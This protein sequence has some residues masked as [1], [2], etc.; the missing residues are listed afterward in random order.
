MVLQS[1]CLGG[2]GLYSLDHVI[3][4][5]LEESLVQSISFCVIAFIGISTKK[6]NVRIS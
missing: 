3:S 6:A 1:P 5:I 2:V 4:D